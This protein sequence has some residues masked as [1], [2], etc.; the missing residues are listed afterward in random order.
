M[1]HFKRNDT[2]TV[3]AGHNHSAVRQSFSG[4]SIYDS[5]TCVYLD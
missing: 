2:I 1:K 3:G 4:F 5:C